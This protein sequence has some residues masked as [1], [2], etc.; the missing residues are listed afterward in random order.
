[1]CS[2]ILY[3]EVEDWWESPP[4]VEV[5]K[6]VVERVLAVVER[7]EVRARLLFALEKEVFFFSLFNATGRVLIEVLAF[8]PY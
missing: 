7:S 3:C 4:V 1:M 2:K 8:L 5:D 6:D